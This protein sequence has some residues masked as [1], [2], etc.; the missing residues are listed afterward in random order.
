MYT[1]CY[2]RSF[3]KTK[4]TFQGLLFYW[5]PTANRR[6]QRGTGRS[7]QQIVEI[8]ASVSTYLHTPWSTVLLEKLTGSQLV[9][10][11][12]EFYGNRRYI[13]AFTSTGHLPLSWAISI[14]SMLPHPTHLRHILIL[15]SHRRLGLPCDLFPSEFPA[16]FLYTTLLSPIRA[17]CPADLILVDLIT[18]TILGEQ[19]RSLSSSL[20]SFLHSPVTLSL[21]G[22]NI[23]LNT[24]SLR[25]SLSVSDQVSLPYKTRDKIIVLYI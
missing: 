7:F 12:S 15:S 9:K 10:T 20:C 17:T 1:G 19:Y 13:T 18:R 24:L 6:W 3:T 21:L 8:R 4:L 5:Q 22:P 23:L 11:L 2:V 14:H 25:S 16:T